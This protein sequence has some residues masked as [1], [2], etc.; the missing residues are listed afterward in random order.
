MSE[1]FS[2]VASSFF[3]DARSRTSCNPLVTPTLSTKT[4]PGDSTSNHFMHAASSETADKPR[5]KRKIRPVFKQLT[6]E[7][8]KDFFKCNSDKNEKYRA[9]YVAAMKRAGQWPTEPGQPSHL[10]QHQ[11]WQAARTL[12]SNCSWSE[13][14]CIKD[15]KRIDIWTCMVIP[16]IFPA[17]DR[18]QFSGTK[19]I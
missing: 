9:E 18:M 12:A 16:F 8:L 10:E 13:V 4:H 11:Q 19:G 7:E 17:P 2:P 3:G 14:I 5:N 1:V 6:G 15:Y